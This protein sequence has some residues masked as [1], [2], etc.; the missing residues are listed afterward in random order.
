MIP[1][2][3]AF[4]ETVKKFGELNIVVNNAG[5]FN[6]KKWK[7]V[8][9]VNLVSGKIKLYLCAILCIVCIKNVN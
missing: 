8:V 6:E 1:I 4:K 9:S 3:E 7:Y 5:L 2:S